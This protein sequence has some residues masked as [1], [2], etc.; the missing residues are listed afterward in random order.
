MEKHLDQNVQVEHTDNEFPADD[1]LTNVTTW[2]KIDH[3]DD[4]RGDIDWTKRQI[5]A[6]VSLSGL[7]VGKWAQPPNLAKRFPD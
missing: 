4:S 3:G 6:V 1:Q 2:D 7:W 5:V